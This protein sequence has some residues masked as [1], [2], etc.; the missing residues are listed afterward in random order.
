M[1]GRTNFQ[2]TLSR[3]NKL[4][5]KKK[6]GKKKKQMICNQTYAEIEYF[7]AEKRIQNLL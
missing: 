7:H 4:G 6:K 2:A 1:H 3:Y 5:F